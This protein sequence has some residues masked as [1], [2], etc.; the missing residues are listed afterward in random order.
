[1][2]YT[3]YTVQQEHEKDMKKIHRF[4]CKSCGKFVRG[5]ANNEG[6]M[7]YSYNCPIHGSTKEM[8]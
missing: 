8:K 2:A 7:G 3:L 1:M 6:I 5:S 4:Y